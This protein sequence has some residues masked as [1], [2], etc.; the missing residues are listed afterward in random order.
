MLATDVD[1]NVVTV[2]PRAALATSVVP[3]CDLVLHRP[4]AT[5]DAVRLRSHG[6]AIPARVNEEGP[7]PSI[8]LGE[9]VGGVAPGQLACLL[10]GD[11][12][13]GYATIT[14]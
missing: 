1:A 14:R 7:T 11:V 13:V 12:V 2:G 5:V 8:D 6:A 9:A 4:A 10:E 3:V